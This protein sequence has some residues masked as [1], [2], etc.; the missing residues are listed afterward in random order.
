M[1]ASDSKSSPKIVSIVPKPNFKATTAAQLAPFAQPGNPGRTMKV[2]Q[3]S[4]ARYTTAT[5][6]DLRRV[7]RH[8]VI[9]RSNEYNTRKQWT[10]ITTQKRSQH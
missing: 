5:T 6:D 4:G 8:T 2:L 3:G 9:T 7:Y 1:E 10:R